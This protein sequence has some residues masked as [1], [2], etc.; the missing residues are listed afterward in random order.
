MESIVIN[1]L[2]PS[3]NDVVVPFSASASTSWTSLLRYILNWTGDTGHPSGTA[4]F[5]TV[6]PHWCSSI[7]CSCFCLTW[8]TL[9]T[10]SNIHLPPCS[11]WWATGS[12]SWG[13]QTLL[14]RLSATYSLVFL[15][16]SP[17]EPDWT[18]LSCRLYYSSISWISSGVY[19]VS[20]LSPTTQSMSVTSLLSSLPR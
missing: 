12:F 19:G 8:M 16:P 9:S 20:G 13:G 4:V 7:T 5:T 3:A 10:L 18:I 2:Q 11:P 14:L 17:S 1:Q 6:S 15:L